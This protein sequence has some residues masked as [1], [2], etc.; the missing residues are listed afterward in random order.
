MQVRRYCP[1]RWFPSK[2][3]YYYLAKYA[4]AEQRGSL[5]LLVDAI[6]RPI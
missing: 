5:L 2:F 1:G 6:T 4:M 3:G